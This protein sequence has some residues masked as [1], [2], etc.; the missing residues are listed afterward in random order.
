MI[1]KEAELLDLSQHVAQLTQNEFYWTK[2]L[3]ALKC[4]KIVEQYFIPYFETRHFDQNPS[5]THSEH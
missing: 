1:L 2:Q 3:H 5:Q 4:T